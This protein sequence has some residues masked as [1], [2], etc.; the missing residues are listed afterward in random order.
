[1]SLAIQLLAGIFP[2]APTDYERIGK[3]KGWPVSVRVS[4]EVQIHPVD[5]T[6]NFIVRR[7]FQIIARYAD[8]TEKVLTIEFGFMTDCGTIL[9]ILRLVPELSPTR[10]AT[11]YVPHDFIFVHRKWDDGTAITLGEADWIL[12]LILVFLKAPPSEQ[13]AIYRG[14]R[15]G[16]WAVWYS[17]NRKRQWL[18]RLAAV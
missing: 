2:N 7:A 4:G 11:A 8:G 6:D 17:G 10:W 14:L 9:R 16:S 3:A 13:T 18:R 12:L 1:M 15:L 5:G